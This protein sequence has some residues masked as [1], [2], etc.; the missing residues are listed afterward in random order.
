MVGIY[1]AGTLP[2]SSMLRT[3]VAVAVAAFASAVTLLATYQ[4]FLL[5]V[6]LMPH[7]VTLGLILL[8][9][10]LLCIFACAC[11]GSAAHKW[12]QRP[13]DDERS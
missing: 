7:G 2:A 6:P 13:L 9:L 3:L 4:A 12:R 11:I 8:G 5:L 1:S 10:S